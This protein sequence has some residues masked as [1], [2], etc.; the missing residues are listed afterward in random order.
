MKK[1]IKIAESC[2]VSLSM[3]LMVGCSDYLNVV[4][5]GV[6]TVETAFSTRT[7]A[8]KFLFTCYNFIED[9]NGY[10]FPG[11]LGSDEFFWDVDA[12]SC[13]NKEGAKIFKG[14]QSASSPIRD[15][16]GS[17][18]RWVGIRNCNIFLENIDNVPD[19]E[20]WEKIR[21]IAEV[22]F[23]KAYYHYFMMTFYGPIPIIDKNLDMDAS[24]EDV[25]IYREPIDDVVEYIVNLLDEC[26]GDLPAY[27]EDTENETGRI[28]RSI[29]RAIKAK[30]LVWAA[31]PLFNGNPDYRNFVDKRGTHLFP[32]EYDASKWERARDAVKEAINEAEGNGHQLYEYQRTFVKI[33]D[34][35]ALNYTLRGCVVEKVSDNNYEAIWPCTQGNVRD[36]SKYC[37][38]NFFPTEQ[39]VSEL[40]APLKIA[41]QYYSA[42]GVPIE[43]DKY[44]DYANRY[45]YS[46]CTDSTQMYYIKFGETTA[47]LNYYREPRFYAHL[48]FDRGIWQTTTLA[49]SSFPVI[50]NRSG[51]QHGYVYSAH[52]IS[53]GYFIKKLVHFKN[54]TTTTTPSITRFMMPIVRLADLYLLYA[55]TLNECKSAPDS[56]VYEYVD[57]IRK[58]AGLGGVVESWENYSTIP[59]KPSTKDGMRE[60]I[61]RERMIELAFEGQ[62][63]FDLRRWKDAMTYHNQDVQGWDYQSQKPEDYYNVVT[64]FT[65][66]KYKTKDYFWPIRIS[67]LDKN[68]NLVQN[69]GW[70]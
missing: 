13:Y 45:G 51:E 35:T 67:D 63:F 16:W 2:I 49:E 65:D 29:N 7:N 34:E 60:I 56:E 68:P 55:E 48:G 31:S 62:R 32:T 30:T 12:S 66:R 47:N 59:D 69:P 61:K 41:E 22:K 50:K 64:Y 28:T 5:D 15:F 19:L 36:L 52:H 53:T 8:E 11:N 46:T 10:N 27:I 70:E 6:A 17:R 4:P 33:S 9:P 14:E 39:E 42:A 23:L 25:R 38:P 18:N 21:W 3:L 58:R 20:E 37:M 44:Y 24:V 54:S 1:L 43:E 40:C 26:Y 57:K